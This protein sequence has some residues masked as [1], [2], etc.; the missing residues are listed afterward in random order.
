MKILLIIT[1]VLGIIGISYAQNPSSLKE[2]SKTYGSGIDM[3]S[4]RINILTVGY[5]LGILNGQPTVYSNIKWKGQ[6]LSNNCLSNEK[7][8][9]FLSIGTDSL[10]KYI[11][12]GSPTDVVAGAGNYEWGNHPFSGTVSWDRLITKN[13][14][15]GNNLHFF[16]TE[17][18][19]AIWNQGFVVKTIKV[20]TD[21]GRV[22]ILK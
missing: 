2:G 1:A 13:F 20:V 5:K 7:F 10:P 9:L 22:F 21:Q 4:C 17:E 14:G 12:A 15:T 6:D 11:Y 19:K 8:D 18:A 3:G 16:T